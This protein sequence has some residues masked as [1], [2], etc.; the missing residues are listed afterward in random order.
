MVVTCL[1]VELCL[2]PTLNRLDTSVHSSHIQVT[3]EAVTVNHTTR[4]QDLYNIYEHTTTNLTALQVMTLFSS[5]F[6]VSVMSSTE[7]SGGT[8]S[9]CSAAVKAAFSRA[10]SVSFSRALFRQGVPSG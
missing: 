10:L 3:K 2:A 8:P 6:T 9:P 5:G 4:I 7:S 1:S